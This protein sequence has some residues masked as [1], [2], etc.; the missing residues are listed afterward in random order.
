MTGVFT[1]MDAPIGRL[2]GNALEVKES[3]EI[4][5][6]KGPEDTREL[7]VVLGAEML[8]LGGK[9][10]TAEEGK[11]LI[12]AVLGDGRALAKFRELVAAQGGN[13]EVA[14]R[15]DAILPKASSRR[16]VSARKTGFVDAIDGYEIGIASIHLG[17][18]R[19]RTS[20]E[21]DPGVG[22]ELAAIVGDRVEIGQPLAYLHENG[23]GVA[24]ATEI[25]AKAFHIADDARPQR[26]R[27]LE[28]IR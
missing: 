13:P 8:L 9:A 27:I 25:V 20:D 4:L 23:R 16:P 22:I 7:T 11:K 19:L 17:G 12:E 15:P 18:G 6:G 3:I 28:V 2:I 26:S 10:K 1:D 24:E 14:D 21:I 5:S